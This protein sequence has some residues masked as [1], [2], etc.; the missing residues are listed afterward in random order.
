MVR[1][2]FIFSYWIFIWYLLYFFRILD[3]YNPKFVIIIGIIENIGILV[4]MLYYRTH[5]KLVLLFIIMTIIL[6]IIPIYTIYYEPI[7]SKD[8]VAT[9][10]LFIIYL[11][12]IFLNNKSMLDFTKNTKDLIIHNKNTLPGMRFLRE[13]IP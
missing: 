9:F 3:V 12:W 5:L 2:D 11:G 4:L 13:F 8:I 1:I 6:K 10:I 7:H